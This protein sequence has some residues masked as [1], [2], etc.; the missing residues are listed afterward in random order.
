MG[1]PLTHVSFRIYDPVSAD[2]LQNFP[3]QCISGFGYNKRNS[4]LFQQ[5]G[6]RNIRLNIF[7]DGHNHNVE[8]SQPQ[9]RQ[10]I[11]IGSVRLHN[12]RHL[13]ADFL[14]P[15]HIRINSQHFMTQFLQCC[16]HTGTKSAQSN[17]GKLFCDF[18]HRTTPH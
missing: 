6:G 14:H 11:L 2:S 13:I 3:V 10:S 9:C 16:C 15:I 1:H 12:M 8:I 7:A 17:Y 18:F 5:Q 4:H